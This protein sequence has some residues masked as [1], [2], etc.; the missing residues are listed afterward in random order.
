MSRKD[1]TTDLS[2]RVNMHLV[3]AVGI[4]F[5]FLINMGVC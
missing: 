5:R 2:T 1:L 4:A 3:D